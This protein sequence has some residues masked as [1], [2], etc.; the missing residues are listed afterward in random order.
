MNIANCK[1]AYLHPPGQSA[2]CISQFALVGGSGCLNMH[3]I[4]TSALTRGQVREVDRRAVAEYGMLGLVLMENAGRGC[5]DVLYQLLHP[6]PSPLPEGEGIAGESVVIVCG[7]GNNA[8]DGFVI[9]RHLDIR[10]IGVKLVLLGA[11]A[12]LHGDAA[13]NYQIVKRM[14]LA[15]VDLSSTYGDA[16]FAQEIAGAEWIVDALLGTG[17]SGSPRPP[18]DAAIRQMN[19]AQARRLAVDLPSGLDCD[20]GEPAEPT[21]RADHTCTFVATK[22][23]FA[24]PRAVEY[25]GQVHVIDI[26]AP[27]RLIEQI[28]HVS[29]QGSAL[30][31]H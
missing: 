17:A 24:N 18:L 12:E 23:G 31:T 15:I 29:I 16:A 4:N 7:K 19:A 11:P 30:G 26:G 3:S 28:A 5:V 27:R 6:H 25:L 8:G 2:F 10:G 22:V 13:A 20:S 1:L 9:A 14:D 21:F